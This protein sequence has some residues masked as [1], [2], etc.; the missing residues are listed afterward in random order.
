MSPKVDVKN[1][2]KGFYHPSSKQPKIIKVPPLHYIAISG[3]GAPG[4]DDFQDT[5][6]A[7][8]GVAFTLKFM[9]KGKR[10]PKGWSD[11]KMTP[12]EAL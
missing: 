12:P 5:F 3:E 2:W 4:A 6:P 7:L 1:I 11:W 10:P 8:Y 9:F